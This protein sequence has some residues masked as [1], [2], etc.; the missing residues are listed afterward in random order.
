MNGA[1]PQSPWRPFNIDWDRVVTEVQG[2]TMTIDAPITCAIEK[3]WG[4]GEMMKY[5]D[6]GRIE[7]VA[8]RTC[9][10]C[11]N[12]IRPCARGN[13][14]T[15]I[16][17]TTSAE[18]YYADENHYA[19]FIIFDNLKHGWVRHAT[20]LHF[21]Y[22]MVGTQ[23]G[24]MDHG[25]GLRLARADLAAH[26]RAAVHLCAAGQLTLVQRCHSDKGR[27]SFMT[28]QPSRAGTSFSTARPR[29]RSRRASRTSSGPPATF[30][31]ISRRR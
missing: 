17:Q 30:T 29:V 21:V 3:R 11:R 8:S 14:A 23:R 24:A 20:A 31:T 18:E 25:A 26:G 6:P 19:N 22:S 9:A 5:E 15:W 27:H 1:T 7:N 10:A 28:G 4:G 2:N 16:A 12:S 13:T